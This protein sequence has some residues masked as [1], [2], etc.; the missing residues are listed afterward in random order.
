MTKKRAIKLLM[1]FRYSRK[2]A[3]S[4]ISRYRLFLT[5]AEIAQAAY[6]RVKFELCRDIPCR[7]TRNMRLCKL[8]AS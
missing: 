6:E 4:W 1:S 2:Q 3:R 8:P 7:Q 5:H